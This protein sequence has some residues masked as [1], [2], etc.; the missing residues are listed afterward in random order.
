MPAPRRRNA[1]QIS[2]DKQQLVGVR[3]GQAE[4]TAATESIHA[5]GRIVPDETRITRIQ[6][7]NRWLD[8]DCIC[9]LHRQV[10]GKGDQLLTLYSPELLAA[11]Q[12]YLLALEARDRHD[13]QFHARSGQ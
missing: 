8:Y 9:G 3:Y 10:N 1:L 6:A 11:Q 4:W 13:A 2:P 5:A 7:R 12:E